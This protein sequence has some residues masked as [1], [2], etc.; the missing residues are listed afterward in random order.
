MKPILN[1]EKFPKFLVVND[2]P[3]KRPWNKHL[4]K[5]YKKG[6]IVKVAPFEQQKR[7]DKYDDKFT[8]VKSNNNPIWFRKRYVVILRKSETNKFD[9]KCTED[10][11]SFNLLTRNDKK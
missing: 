6:E 2:I 7:N 4:T 3:E 9:Y 11:E 1:K 8:F 5:P 10:W